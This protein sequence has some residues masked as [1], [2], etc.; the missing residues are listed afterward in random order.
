MHFGPARYAEINM[1]RRKR[2]RRDKERGKKRERQRK[3]TI[4]SNLI[5]LCFARGRAGRGKQAVVRK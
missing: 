4:Q 5:Q 3:R 1:R 2:R